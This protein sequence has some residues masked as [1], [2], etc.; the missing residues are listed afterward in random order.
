MVGTF[1]LPLRLKTFLSIMD[2]KLMVLVFTTFRELFIL[3][4]VLCIFIIFIVSLHLMTL[5]WT[6]NDNLSC[7]PLLPK[8]EIQLDIKMRKLYSGQWRMRF[9]FRLMI[10]WIFLLTIWMETTAGNQSFLRWWFSGLIE[11]MLTL[12]SLRNWYVSRNMPRGQSM[13]ESYIQASL[14]VLHQ[15]GND[16]LMLTEKKLERDWFDLYYRILDVI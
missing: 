2:R 6:T 11:H 15:R 12:P 9:P 14:I 1:V 4:N 10:F 16:A 13:S 8:A 3:Y 5:S 7:Q